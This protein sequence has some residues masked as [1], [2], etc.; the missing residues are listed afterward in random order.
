M[1]ITR[2]RYHKRKIIGGN[3]LGNVYDRL[4]GTLSTGSKI[5]TKPILSVKNKILKPVVTKAIPYVTQKAIDSGTKEI[6]NRVKTGIKDVSTNPKVRK[7]L[8]DRSRAILSNIIAG[9]GMKRL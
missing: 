6:L 8:N 2:E 1:L 7:V 3:L 5:I 4:K 9:S